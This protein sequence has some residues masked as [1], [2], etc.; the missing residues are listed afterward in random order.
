MSVPAPTNRWYLHRNGETGGPYDEQAI[1]GWIKS[2][3]RDAVVRAEAA[4]STSHWL[5]LAAHAPFASALLPETT[6]SLEQKKPTSNTRTA[7]LGLILLTIVALAI[8][9]WL[10]A[11]MGESA[12]EGV[13]AAAIRAPIDVKNEIISVP[14][15]HCR[16]VPI[17]LPYSGQ[18]NLEVTVVK[19]EHVNVYVVNATDWSEFEKAETSFFGGKFHH[20]P[21]F[22]AT[23]A[24]R[25]RTSGALAEGAYFVVLENPTFGLLVD[26]SFDVEV[27]ARLQP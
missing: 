13:V 19:G 22:Q 10:R 27:K 9:L 17:Q 21:A 3:M 26:P 16:G 7:V 18:M 5:P 6:R 8:F 11:L 25:S 4:D 2:G 1:V 15:Q 20:Y 12:V 23:R 24:S 14:A